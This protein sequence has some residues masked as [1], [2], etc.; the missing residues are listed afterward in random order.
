MKDGSTVAYLI[1]QYPQ[2]SHS[3]IRREIAALE[4]RGL[5][6][7]RYSLRAAPNNLVEPADLAERDKTRVVLK[8]GALKLLLTLIRSFFS[9]PGPTLSAVRLALK[10]GRHSERGLLIHLIYVAEACVLRQWLAQ[11]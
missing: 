10:V 9:R 5:R 4:A 11:D 1:N 7:L 6:V 8:E 3:F 2:T